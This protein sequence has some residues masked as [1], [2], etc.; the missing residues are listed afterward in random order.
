[1][2]LHRVFLWLKFTIEVVELTCLQDEL[3]TEI[4]KGTTYSQST[5]MYSSA[6]SSYWRQ[7]VSRRTIVLS[8]TL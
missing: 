3:Y 4:N 2:H 6:V 1:M 5:S 8:T 7:L